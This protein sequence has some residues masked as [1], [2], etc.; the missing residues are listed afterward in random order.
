MPTGARLVSLCVA[1]LARVAGS[2]LIAINSNN[3]NIQYTPA[4]SWEA[5]GAPGAYEGSAMFLLAKHEQ[6]IVSF[7][8]PRAFRHNLLNNENPPN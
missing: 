8:F 3:T 7:A 4:G 1:L 5:I 2:V 6:G